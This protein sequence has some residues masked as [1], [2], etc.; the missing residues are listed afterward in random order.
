MAMIVLDL[1]PHIRGKPIRG[2]PPKVRG[3]PG[4]SV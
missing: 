3:D 2:W 1:R 4:K